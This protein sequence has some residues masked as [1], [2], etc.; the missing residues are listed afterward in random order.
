MV[1]GEPL[2]ATFYL[3]A[4]DG[5]VQLTLGEPVQVRHS[6]WRRARADQLLVRLADPGRAAV[7][8]SEAV[9]APP[10]PVSSLQLLHP[11]ARGAGMAQYQLWDF[12]KDH[13]LQGVP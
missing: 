6:M 1:D 7:A 13:A 3:G 10:P 2:L 12:Q 5:Y 9:A 4:G 8:I 11:Q